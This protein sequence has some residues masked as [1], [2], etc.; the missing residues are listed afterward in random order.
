MRYQ[1]PLCSVLTVGLWALAPLAMAGGNAAVQAEKEDGEQAQDK[2]ADVAESIFEYL[3]L[4][5]DTNDDG[6]IL[7]QEYTRDDAHWERLDVNKDGVL[8]E[9]D[10]ATSGRRGKRGRPERP[11][12][13]SR[14]RVT[15]PAAGEQAPD[16][17][18]E[19]VVPKKASASVGGGQETEKPNAKKPNAGKKEAE[20]PKPIK[21]SDF[22]KKKRPV[23][24]VFGSYT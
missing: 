17:E 2:P 6:E 16:F 8:T 20:K 12:Y 22:A 7:R 10:F 4:S 11:D 3:L 18:L 23:A 1:Y 5:Y 24:L 14:K 15:P 21:L 19:I 9:A 13:G